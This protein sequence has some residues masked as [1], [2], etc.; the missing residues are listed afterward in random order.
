VGGVSGRRSAAREQANVAVRAE[1]STVGTGRARDPLALEVRL[2]GSLLGQVIAEQAG[3]DLLDLVERI[4]RAAIRLRRDDDP[5]DRDALAA[6]LAGLDVSRAEIVI[7][8]FSLYFRLVNLAEERDRVRAARRRERLERDRPAADSIAGTLADL[9]AAGASGELDELLGRLRISPILTAHPTEARRR[10]L[11]LALRRVER[12]LARLDDHDL[13][14]PEDRDL[15]RRL[16]EEITLLWRT[17]DLRTVAPTPLDEVRTALAFFDETLFGVVPRLYRLADAAL[18]GPAGSDGEATDADSTGTRP[19]R[20][21][22]FLR[23][24]S[25]I[26]GD[27]DGNPAVTAEVTEGALRIHADHVLRGYEAVARRLAQTVA[28]SV[29]PDDVAR[30]LV[31]RLARDAELLPELDRQMRRRFP[32]EPYRQ[33]FG[34][35][36]ERLR[37]TRAFLT[38]QQA[39][40]T[41]RYE[42]AAELD[43]E[44]VEIQEA[45]VGDGLGR[46]AW[47]EVQDF[48]WQLVT[49]GFHL[50]GLEI[51][52]HSAVHRATV[53]ALATNAATSA[54]TAVTPA[55]GGPA[56]EGPAGEAAP[57]VSPAEVIE[58]LR[59]SATVQSRFGEVAV[60]RYIISFTAAASDIRAVTEL[61]AA[62]GIMGPDGGLALD[63]VPLFEDAATLETAG[64]VLDAILS[65][66][67]Y[68]DH[69]GRRGDRQEVMLG[70]S[71]SNKESGYLAGNWL[72]H[73]A[74][75]TLVA[76]ARRHAVELTLFHGRGGAIGRGGGPANRAI[77][78]L[79]PGALDGRLKLTEQGEVIAENYADPGIAVRHLDRLTAA[80]IRASTA[81]H[82]AALE[83]AEASGG[84]IL[85]ELA[86]T[87]RDA[88]RTLV[89]D[90]G[91]VD[92]FRLVTPIDEIA[93]LRL[94][95]RPAARAR[96][97]A[98]SAGEPPPRIADLRAIPWVFAWAQARIDLPG[99]FGLG[100]AL[101]SF[102]KRRGEAGMRE[103]GRLYRTWPFLASLIDNAELALARADIGVARQ[104]A[105]LASGD[106]HARRWATIEAEHG[107]TVAWL[108]RLT[109][110]S[111]LLEDEPE[112][113][114]RIGLRDPY[115]D[116]LSA[117]QVMLLARLRACDPDDP[118]RDRLLRLVQLTVNG[119]AAGLQ[120]TG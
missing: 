120:A 26:G 15:R 102:A 101:E 43:A 44:V 65:D 107:R 114:R 95:S 70:Y 40:L 85:D 21:A 100:S 111:Q 117:L 48:R 119:I 5:T 113:R 22:A 32:N 29:D 84:P 92:F 73:R 18:D 35:M 75:A 55:G 93:T 77:L 14:T 90:P 7:R 99:W 23:W 6:E 96:S 63:L 20:I 88:Y 17:A 94:G 68:R 69:V 57:G 97:G 50:A 89:D 19:P 2:L 66:P 10:T 80:V 64:E 37:R 30:P 71:D 74:Q 33:R 103:L 116:S 62:A 42:S 11:L 4:R 45:L 12:I 38:G 109:G 61:A 115:V 8:A 87:S 39:P 49:F 53:A 91:F 41:G 104:Y 28:A 36:A 83:A 79:A 24:G 106:E 81:D 82:A 86:T 47:G 118:E 1:P 34:F 59:A 98:R 56:G 60:E 76:A 108:A 52:Q 46:I 78:G 16:R 3:R 9:R 31:T 13:P 105:A 25:W 58:T 51:R 72:I 54:I 110:R 27:R 112:L 67:A